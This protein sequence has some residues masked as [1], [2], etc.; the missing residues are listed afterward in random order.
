[1]LQTLVASLIVAA[2]SSLTFVAYKHPQGFARMF[3]AL[4]AGTG[5]IGLV[6]LIWQ[7]LIIWSS[8]EIIDHLARTL[9]ESP[10]ESIQQHAHKLAA[11]VRSSFICLAVLGGTWGYLFL[12]QRLPDIL[13][14][15]FGESPARTD[16]DAQ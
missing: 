6:Y 1:M 10:L 12:L 4:L 3:P 2:V 11:S 16:E 7:V 8:A 14:H 5:T 15:G 13:E 9:P